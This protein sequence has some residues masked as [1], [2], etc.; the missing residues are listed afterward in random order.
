M[1]C[2]S[3]GCSEEVAAVARPIDPPPSL[4]SFRIGGLLRL[5]RLEFL[6]F[7]QGDF[8]DPPFVP[9]GL[10]TGFEPHLDDAPG[11]FLADQVGGKAKHVGIVVAA[12]HLRG[13]FVVAQRRTDPANL[14]G[15]DAHADAAAAQQDAQL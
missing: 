7:V 3:V 14:V 2:Y 11:E 6:F 13:Q 5:P 9:A 15:G 10:K 1:W 4:L 8:L 12:R